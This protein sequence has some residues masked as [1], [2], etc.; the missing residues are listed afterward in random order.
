[1]ILRPKTLWR[2]PWL[3]REIASGA[4]RSVEALLRATIARQGRFHFLQI[5]ANDGMVNDS[6]HR[7]F[8]R[9]PCPPDAVRGVCVE[10]QHAAFA[11]LEQVCRDRPGVTCCHA[12]LGPQPGRRQMYNIA[13]PYRAARRFGDFGDRLASFDRAHIIRHWNRMAARSWRR[14]IGEDAYV[15]T[16]SVD[17]ITFAQLCDRTGMT[18]FDCL[19]IDAEGYDAEILR[20]IDLA[21]CG[22]R[23]VVLEH[24]HLNRDDK[25]YCYDRL[26]SEGFRLGG[27]SKDLWGMRTINAG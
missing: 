10:P 26:K 6:I 4:P 23:A 22:V 24:K 1:M 20:M 12:A 3:A 14:R 11:R 9:L 18:G 13:A 21:A 2:M 17:C 7:I 27:S 16:E 5:S 15:S 19:V 8:A 25:K